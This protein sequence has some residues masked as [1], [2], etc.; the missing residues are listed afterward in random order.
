MKTLSII[1]II[2]ITT[3]TSFSATDP[4]EVKE[5][6]KAN[7]Y[8]IQYQSAQKG[9]VEV[10]ILN[11][12]SEIIFSEVITNLNTFVRPYN[13]SNLPEGIYIFMVEDESGQHM[14]E[15]IHSLEKPV[16]YAHVAPLPNQNNKYWLNV[17]SSA[18][19]TVNVRIL[20]QWGNLLFEQSVSVTGGY[21]VIYDLNKVKKNDQVIFEV[22]DGSGR[23]YTATF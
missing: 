8:S 10:S 5:S 12:E 11:S 23:L 14:E 20:S 6:S 15:V 18:K 9:K 4:F 21:K 7:V 2:I 13:F 19:E 16:N 1:T 22:T 3:L 17:Y